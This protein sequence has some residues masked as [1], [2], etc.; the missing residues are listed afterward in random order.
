[1]SIKSD[2][3]K[4][5]N[6]LNDL[7]E[8]Y[9]NDIIKTEH[10]LEVIDQ[11]RDKNP[12]NAKIAEARASK[13]IQDLNKDLSILIDLQIK[14]PNTIYFYESSDPK[15]FTE[16]LTMVENNKEKVGK[17]IEVMRMAAQKE[18]DKLME[19]HSFCNHKMDLPLLNDESVM[20]YSVQELDE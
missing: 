6:W 8:L 2:L 5:H 9:Q 15:T 12:E 20:L 19:W 4:I 7:I 16:H 1:M 14:V 10:H 11:H 18:K 13:E 3:Q 17:D